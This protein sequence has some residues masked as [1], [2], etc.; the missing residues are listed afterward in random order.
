MSS[1]N[2]RIEKKILLRATR[3]RVWRA[4]TDSAEFGTWFGMKLEGAF[5][6]G[7]IIRGAMTP[8]AVDADVAKSQAPYDGHPVELIVDRIEPMHRFSFRWPAY[9]VE[10][11][12]DDAAEMTLV[13]FELA[14]VNGGTLLTVTETGFEKI[15]AARRA[16]AL[17]S[18]EGG[19]EAQT[20]LIEK[21]LAQRG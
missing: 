1:D 15:P 8:T 11:G 2:D 14:D 5:A 18:N 7:A 6:E 20:H 19:W 9:A 12:L 13:T 4:V 21:Y 3:E 17:K 16:E 10:P